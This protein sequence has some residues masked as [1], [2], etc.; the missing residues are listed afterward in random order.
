MDLQALKPLRVALA[1]LFFVAC[2]VMFLDLRGPVAA[3]VA[4]IILPLQL[5]PSLA[6]TLVGVGAWTVGLLG[7]VLLTVLAGRVYC[8]TICPLG[9]LQDAVIHF[10]ERRKRRRYRYDRPRYA[11]HYAVGGVTLAA[12][13]AGSLWLLNLLEPFSNFGRMADATMRPVVIGLN[14]AIAMGGAMVGIHA[15]QPV[16]FHPPGVWVFLAAAGALAA[17]VALSYARGRLFCNTLCPAG[18]ILSLLSR[19]SLFKIV[20]DEETCLDCGLCEKVCK[21]ACI[22]AEHKK[23]EYA[24]CVACFN[25]ITACPTVG[26]KYAG[27]G[28]RL[29]PVKEKGGAGSRVRVRGKAGAGPSRR[30][31]LSGTATAML[32]AFTVP[33]D[34]VMIRAAQRGIGTRPVTPPG[35]RGIDHFGSRC[36]ACHLCV[37]VCPTQVLRPALLEYGI[38]G[39]L[40]PR[41][42]FRTAY[43]T[44]DCVLCTTVCPS[45]AILP[46]TPD[47]KK[48]VQIGT[49]KFV[50]E[51]CI[52]ETKKKDC[53]A[54]AEHC[55]TK[56]VTM[57]PYGA[58]MLP[59]LKNDLC[60][61]CGA[62]EH[63]C[64][65]EPHRAIFVLASGE[66][67]RAKRP[68]IEKA[69]PQEDVPTEFPF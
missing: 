31:F 23:V 33:V 18:A 3:W 22:D 53:G 27:I 50:R 43:C 48:D 11:L 7:I 54:C 55:P 9:T 36:T 42:D 4:S 41:M 37:S 61:G 44:Y 63:A 24:A 38:A 51:D 49:A 67:G 10:A 1:T 40:Q 66:H 45:G 8:S 52:V 13:L 15:L 6:K 29:V 59:E 58:L 28:G 34:S 25:C 14:N 39:V 16:P 12:F 57:V 32:G 64:P 68:V 46:L 47:G 62:C 56:A 65:T 35:S 5:V 17:I 26:L 2:A 60:V 21:A 19:V 69:V 30:E 20:I